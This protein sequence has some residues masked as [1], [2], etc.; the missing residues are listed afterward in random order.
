MI[1]NCQ[2]LILIFFSIVLTINS[3]IA[4]SNR[5]GRQLSKKVKQTLT[6]K[7]TRITKAKANKNITEVKVPE[8]LTAVIKKEETIIKPE[9]LPA[10][11]KQP[12]QKAEP[13]NEKELNDEIEEL[14]VVEQEN[15][16]ES[17]VDSAVKTASKWAIIAFNYISSVAQSLWTWTK[18]VAFVKIVE[19]KNWI[20]NQ[21]S[22]SQS[23]SC[24]SHN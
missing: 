12:E 17:S 16:Q 10:E 21:S 20:S 1:N 19:M 23:C 15:I 22:C 2:K 9:V 14:E 3:F 24:N 6:S 5:K 13:I 8:A 11:K 18:E 4:G 7:P